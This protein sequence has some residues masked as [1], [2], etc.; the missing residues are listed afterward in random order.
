[1]VPLEV[2]VAQ[3]VSLGGGGAME[4]AV[5]RALLR[6]E[7]GTDVAYVSELVRRLGAE[8]R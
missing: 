3:A 2:K 1:M 5:G 8:P 6:I 7:V 4:I